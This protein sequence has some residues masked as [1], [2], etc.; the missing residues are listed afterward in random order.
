MRS[1]RRHVPMFH[2]EAICEK[3]DGLWFEINLQMQTEIQFPLSYNFSAC[4]Q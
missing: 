4:S 1:I 2:A 3:R